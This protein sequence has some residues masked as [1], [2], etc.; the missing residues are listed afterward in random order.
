MLKII[1][2]NRIIFIDLLYNIFNIKKK[3]NN[4][5]IDINS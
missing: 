1:G 3:K 4:L 5:K 2:S